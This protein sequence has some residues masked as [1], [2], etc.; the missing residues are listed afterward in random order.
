MRMAAADGHQ[1]R[2]SAHPWRARGLRLLVYAL[3]IADSLVFVRLATS[4]VGVP[5]RSLWLFLLWWLAMSLSATA[6]HDRLAILPV[7][8]DR[9]VESS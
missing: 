9:C 4:V 3:P 5:T 7:G 8:L 1:P 6:A 2:W